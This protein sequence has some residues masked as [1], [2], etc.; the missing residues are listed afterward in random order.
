M[1][2]MFRFL[3]HLL[4]VFLMAA[5]SP[6]LAQGVGE[7]PRT[8]AALKR[9]CLEEQEEILTYRAFAEKAVKEGYQGIARLFAALGA[10]ETVHERNF[11]LLLLSLGFEPPGLGEFRVPVAG[12]RHNLQEAAGRELKDIDR[13][14]REMLELAKPEG[15]AQA[16]RLLAHA[17]SSEKRHRD[18]IEQV[19]RGASLLFFGL[20]VGKTE[21]VDHYF[22]CDTCGYVLLEPPVEGCPVCGGEPA[23]FI[24]VAHE[25]RGP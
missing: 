17:W 8:V 15:H 18:V 11:R 5:A 24:S 21:G 4:V 1:K 23:G 3:A 13:D 2:G 20:M 14:Y 7:F 16:L 12:T 19:Q 9:A 10:A 25:G 6:A 22:V